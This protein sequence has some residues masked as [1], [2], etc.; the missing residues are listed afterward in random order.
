[1]GLLVLVLGCV[2]HRC[3]QATSITVTAVLVAVITGQEQNINAIRR[4][5]PELVL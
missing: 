1:M 5:M 2:I 3:C 4:W